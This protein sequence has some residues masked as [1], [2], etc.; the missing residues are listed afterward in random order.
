MA[1]QRITSGVIADGAIVAT[2][3]GN[4]TVTT[5]KIADAN[6]T[7]AK[8]SA[9]GTANST[10]YLRGDGAWSQLSIDSTAISNGTSNVSV[11]STNGNV[12][13]GTAGTERV[14]VD[15]NGNFQFNSG[16]GSVAV[17]YGCRAWVNFDGNDTS[18]IREDG[19]VSSVT[20]NGT[21]DYTVNFTTAMPDAN[22]C[23]QSTTNSHSG[24]FGVFLGS[25]Q[26]ATTPSTSSVRIQNRR[27]DNQTLLDADAIHVAIFR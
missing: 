17:A 10:T 18:I 15:T 14:R 13:I 7:V 22:Y 1:I 19:N 4:N 2:D 25:Q 23:I 20:D 6:V 12:T 16:Y 24:S 27:T 9:T 11:N 21:G 8:L 26:N 5:A 3:I